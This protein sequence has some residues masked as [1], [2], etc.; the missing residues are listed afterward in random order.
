[1][2]FHDTMDVGI[3]AALSLQDVNVGLLNCDLDM[4]RINSLLAPF[5]SQ[6]IATPQP[7]GMIRSFKGAVPRFNL[8]PPPVTTV[9]SP[10]ASVGMETCNV[11]SNVGVQPVG[12]IDIKL[13]S[14]SRASSPVK[15]AWLLRG[16]DA[17]RPCR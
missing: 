13:G 1:M 10:P 15:E 9:P 2:E 4:D 11:V 17:I 3:A 16:G 7:R 12:V 6:N 8:E 14:G 5:L